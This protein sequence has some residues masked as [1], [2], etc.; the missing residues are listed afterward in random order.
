MKPVSREELFLIRLGWKIMAVTTTKPAVLL[1]R[2]MF[3]LPLSGHEKT[4]AT[5]FRH[6][7]TPVDGAHLRGQWSYRPGWQR[8][9]IRWAVVTALVAFMVGQVVSP[10]LTTTLTVVGG[11][12]LL[13]WRVRCAERESE[14]RRHLRD[15]VAPVWEVVAPYLKLDP[16]TS[17]EGYLSVPADIEEPDAQVELVL[18][19]GWDADEANQARIDGVMHRLVHPRLVAD[20]QPMLRRATWRLEVMSEHVEQNIQPMYETLAKLLGL[21]PNR[22]GDWLIE[23]PEDFEAADETRVRIHLPSGVHLTGTKQQSIDATV[24]RY[25]GRNLQADWSNP[26]V[27]SYTKKGTPPE[28]VRYEGHDDPAGV[29]KL[30][31]DGSGKW[32]ETELQNETPHGFVTAPTRYGKSTTLSVPAAHIRSKGGLAS[33]VDPKRGSFETTFEKVPTVRVHKSH[34]SMGWALEEFFL[35]MVGVEIAREQ[36]ANID[37]F[38][39]RILVIDELGSLMRSLSNNHKLRKARKE[40]DGDPPFRN[41]F[42]QIAMRGGANKHYLAVGAHQP[43]R[44]LFGGTEI[45]AQFGWKIMLGRYDHSVWTTTFGYAKR[46]AW[47]GHKKGRGVIGFGQHEDDIS[48]CQVV[49]LEPAEIIELANSGPEPPAWWM[50]FEM[51][52]WITRE[53][54]EEALESTELTFASPERAPLTYSAGSAH[55]V[56]RTRP[57]GGTPPPPPPP[58]AETVNQQAEEFPG[59]EVETVTVAQA[60]VLPDTPDKPARPPADP[61]DKSPESAK[62]ADTT[63]NAD[64]IIGNREAAEF[65]GMTVETFVRQ[66]RRHKKKHGWFPG[67]QVTPDGKP[68]W[69]REALR[70]WQSSRPIAGPAWAARE[71]MELA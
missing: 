29:L 13:V 28:V 54:V 62:R 56:P 67:E 22:R 16:D 26:Q 6:G 39:E 24:R 10:W 53:V 40:V 1:A 18:P 44:D 34:K 46:L 47:N 45:R 42:D 50:N 55:D 36:G 70:Q 7:T 68:C 2:F 4:D 38:P 5:W 60:G 19:R 51:A 43:R 63:E 69:T 35:S 30:G 48:E 41:Q 14:A 57:T 61:L 21:D 20:W 27:I 58:P 64:L 32:V 59:N 9:L 71:E 3:G 15:V 37:D 52:P 66:R 11:G 49:Y 17:P 33:M 23:L 65:L 25:L 12:V 8:M 31:K